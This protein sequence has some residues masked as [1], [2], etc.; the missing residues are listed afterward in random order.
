MDANGLALRGLLVRH[1][2][3]PNAMAGTQ[4]IVR[5]LAREISTDTYMNIMNQ[6]HPCYRTDDYPDVNRPTTQQEY[7]EAIATAHRAGLTRLDDKRSR[8]WL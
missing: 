2:V 8:F 5:F 3:L 6:Y 1:L 4:Q 7:Q